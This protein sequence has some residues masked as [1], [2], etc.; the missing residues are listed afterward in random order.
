MYKKILNIILINTIKIL[1][2]LYFILQIFVIN[3]LS[4]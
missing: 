4:L 2:Y 1:T 3:L